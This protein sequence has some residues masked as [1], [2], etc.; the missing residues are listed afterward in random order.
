MKNRYISCI[1]DKKTGETISKK[2]FAA[3]DSLR[4]M[5]EKNQLLADARARILW[6]L[7]KAV[8]RNQES[9]K[10]LGEYRDIIYQMRRLYVLFNRAEQ[11][12]KKT[13]IVKSIKEVEIELYS[14][15]IEDLKNEIGGKSDSPAE[16]KAFISNAQKALIDFSNLNSLQ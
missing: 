10:L 11:I 16:T 6:N 12:K 3:R 9:T 2:E 13:H 1:F 14:K 8:Y 4:Y 5:G 7:E 15:A